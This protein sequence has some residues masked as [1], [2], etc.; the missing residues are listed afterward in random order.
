MAE[1]QNLADRADDYR[2][3]I[4]VL[5]LCGLRFSECAALRARSV[6]LMRRRLRMSESA[7]A[8][9]S[10]VNGQ[11]IW[12]IPNTHHSDVPIPRSLIDDLVLQAT[13]KKAEDV[14]FSGPN[15]APIWLATGSDE[16]GTLPSP[17]LVSPDLRPTTSD[18][19]RRR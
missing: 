19:S 6:D 11:M 17:P 18:T 10:E 12:S 9:A 7:S 13:G 4:L 1:L 15:G 16:C 14:L 8:S 3:M 2:L 5:G